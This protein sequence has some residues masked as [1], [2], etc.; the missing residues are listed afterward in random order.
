MLYTFLIYLDVNTVYLLWSLPV[1]YRRSRVGDTLILLR[2]TVNYFLSNFYLALFNV[3]YSLVVG[4]WLRKLAK[5]TRANWILKMVEKHYFRTQL[6]RLR[7]PGR[8]LSQNGVIFDQTTFLAGGVFKG[9]R[10]LIRCLL[11]NAWSEQVFLVYL[12]W[13]KYVYCKVRNLCRCSL[14]L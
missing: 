11:G 4:S 10:D 9:K 14:E 12:W 1:F 2:G 13:S 7:V 6:K 8:Y 5:C 3:P